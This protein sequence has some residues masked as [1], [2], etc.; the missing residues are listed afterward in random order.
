ML[1]VILMTE[2]GWDASGSPHIPLVFALLVSQ[3]LLLIGIDICSGLLLFE[4]LIFP[5]SFTDVK[6]LSFSG[7]SAEL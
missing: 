1:P 2:T 3:V 7:P 6:W 4:K 5:G